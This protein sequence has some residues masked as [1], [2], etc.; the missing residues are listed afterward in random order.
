M[1]VLPRNSRL[2][3]LVALALFLLHMGFPALSISAHGGGTPQLTN[4]EAG[5]YRIY[6]WTQPEP[7]RVG[8]MHASIVVTLPY[9]TITTEKAGAA[10]S[11]LTT[12]VTA[13]DTSLRFKLRND[14]AQNFEVDAL[15]QQDAAGYFYEVDAVLPVEGEWDVFVAVSG[16]RGSG[17]A[18]FSLA[19]LPANSMNWRLVGAI[20][21]GLLGLLALFGIGSRRG[22]AALKDGV[23]SGRRQTSQTGDGRTG[24]SVGASRI[25]GG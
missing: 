17:E 9:G 4:A 23:G 15:S 10:P 2:L 3:P 8:E 25:V 7:V 21:A 1:E 22:R 19:V 16:E 6:V 14:P 13:A 12:A 20:A 5:P 18:S 11:Q 24:Y